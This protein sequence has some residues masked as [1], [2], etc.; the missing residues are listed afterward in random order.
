MPIVKSVTK[1]SIEILLLVLTH[2]QL[3]IKDGTVTLLVLYV[4]KNVAMERLILG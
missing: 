3:L 2:A 4:L 1:V